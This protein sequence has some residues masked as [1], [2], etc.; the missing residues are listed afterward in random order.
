MSGYLPLTRIESLVHTHGF[1]NVWEVRSL[2]W[3]VMNSTENQ[4]FCFVE[5]GQWVWGDS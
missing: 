4:E 1:E 5:D 2:F 3:V